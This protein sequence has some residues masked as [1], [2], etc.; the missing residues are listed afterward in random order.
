M[1]SYIAPVSALTRRVA[2]LSELVLL[3]QLISV[4]AKYTFGSVRGTCFENPPRVT[5][6]SH[7]AAQRTN[8]ET[9]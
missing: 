5:H 9:N 3:Q 7:I 1:T 4:L 6:L 8:T 2:S